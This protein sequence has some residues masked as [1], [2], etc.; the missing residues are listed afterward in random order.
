M[1][2]WTGAL[3][4]KDASPDVVAS[5]PWEIF[6]CKNGTQISSLDLAMVGLLFS[7]R[8]SAEMLASLIVSGVGG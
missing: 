8:T 7:M 1:P 2:N 3:L 5:S 6:G 4:A